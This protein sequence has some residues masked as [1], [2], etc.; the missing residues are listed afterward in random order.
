MRGRLI[1]IKGDLVGHK[2]FGQATLG[3]LLQ[4]LGHRKRFVEENGTSGVDEKILTKEIYFY[5]YSD[6]H[7]VWRSEF[8]EQFPPVGPVLYEAHDD[9]EG[10]AEHLVGAHVKQV[11]GAQSVV[12]AAS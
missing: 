2:H 6:L 10:I 11:A 1:H 9:T 12:E 7:L 5:Y 3:Q 8:P 4:H